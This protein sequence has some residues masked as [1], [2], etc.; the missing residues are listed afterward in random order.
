MTKPMHLFRAASPEEKAR[1]AAMAAHEGMSLSD[2]LREAINCLIYSRQAGI[3]E[4]RDEAYDEVKMLPRM[5]T[6]L[7]E[8][9]TAK[10][11]A[12][13]LAQRKSRARR[14]PSRLCPSCTSVMRYEHGDV[15]RTCVA[16]VAP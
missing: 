13:R 9:R 14:R 1:V 10:Q 2:F 4:Q 15:C 8:G 12:D 11:E 16:G 3:D 6:A 5:A 7:R